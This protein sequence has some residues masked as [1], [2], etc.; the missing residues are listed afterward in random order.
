MKSVITDLKWASGCIEALL[1]ITLF[2]D[3][4]ALPVIVILGLHITIVI[5]A[6]KNNM[7]AYGNILGIVTSLLT[8]IPSMG[9]IIHIFTAFFIIADI[10]RK[11]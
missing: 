5:M 3:V 7:N 11:N 2:K 10:V 9:T 6:K 8:W 4:I 1:G